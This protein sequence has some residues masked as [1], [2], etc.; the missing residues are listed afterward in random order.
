[1]RVS[2]SSLQVKYLEPVKRLANAAFYMSTHSCDYA[3]V[4]D[5][6]G[7]SF[8]GHAY[9]GCEEGLVTMSIRVF[10]VFLS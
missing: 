3:E 9:V 5:F 4:Q 7:A 8:T 1:M 10:A 6:V 2:R